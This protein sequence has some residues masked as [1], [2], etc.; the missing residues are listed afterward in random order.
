MVAG[1]YEQVAV[2]GVDGVKLRT[3]Q[4]RDP[5]LVDA[6]LRGELVG[7]N[8]NREFGVELLEQVLGG[9]FADVADAGQSL[10]Q[11]R[12]VERRLRNRLDFDIVHTLTRGC[13]V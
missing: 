5:L 2:T 8:P 12:I 1:Q 4:R 9:Q 6:D 10:D 7:V 11:G 13:G 3:R